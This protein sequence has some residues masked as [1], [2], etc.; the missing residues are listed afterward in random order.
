VLVAITAWLAAHLP[1]AAFLVYRL[2]S[3]RTALR[4][5]RL[6]AAASGRSEAVV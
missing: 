3:W 4:R 6:R 2:R 1:F 5:T